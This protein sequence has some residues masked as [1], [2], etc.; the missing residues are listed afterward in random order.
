M[1]LSK[2]AYFECRAGIAGDM[3][4]GALIDAGV[5]LEYLV[6]K[7]NTLGIESEYRLKISSV[8]HQ[9][10]VASKADVELLNPGHHH[11][12]H[13][14]R[15]LPEIEDLINKADLPARA[16]D[17]SLAVFQTLAV[18]E[19][20][21]HGVPPEKVHFHE[22]GAI[23]A[24]VDIV[25][26]CLGLDWLGIDQIYFSSLPTGGGTVKAAHGVLPVPVPAVLR[27]W[28]L[29]E[30]PVYSNGIEKELVTPTGAAIAVTLASKFGS[31]PAMRLQKVGLG[32]GTIQLPIPNILRLWIG[33]GVANESEVETIS[34]LE[35]QIDDLSPQ[36]IGYVFDELFA[37]GALD[38]FTQ[39]IAMKKS[40]LGT[41]LT[42]ICH[43]D[44]VKACES[45]LFRETSTLG[46]RHS[47][48]QRSVLDREIQTVETPYGQVR[49]KVAGKGGDITNVQPEYED[50]AK[51]AKDNGVAWREVH[52]IALE[53]WYAS[54]NT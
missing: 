3:C 39:A 35:T 18:A 22:V 23:D 30:V 8:V 32:A 17:W 19:G 26:T 33:E 37:V 1:I 41:L 12:H 43:P 4:L 51:L 45:V 40:R 42:V 7:L 14:H 25:G 28:E 31:P 20:K 2:I 52:R 27:L 6:S 24:I 36:A 9:G 5:P 53:K 10:Q 54:S 34:V 16:R 13:Y 50:C 15:H 46:I 38:V 44:R 47:T 49:V 48:Q 29:R 11:H 21:V